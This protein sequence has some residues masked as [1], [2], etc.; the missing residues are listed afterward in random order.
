MLLRPLIIDP[1]HLTVAPADYR[2]P[3]HAAGGIHPAG[4]MLSNNTLILSS[5]SNWCVYALDTADG[6]S[7]KLLTDAHDK[8]GQGQLIEWAGKI[9][10]PDAKGWFEIDPDT[11]RTERISP[12]RPPHEGYCRSVRH[13]RSW[14]YG[15]LAHST[16][17]YFQ[18]NLVTSPQSAQ[19]ATEATPNKLTTEPSEQ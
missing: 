8:M 7:V 1:V 14:H 2:L 18:V 5:S 16:R 9:Y 13:F 4:V 19:N 11:L 12:V 17:G 3:P 10:L 6:T 15:I